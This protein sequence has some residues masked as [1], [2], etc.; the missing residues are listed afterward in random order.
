[1]LF[2]HTHTQSFASV[3]ALVGGP[4]AGLVTDRWGRKVALLLVGVPY[5][6]G[7]LMMTLAHLIGDPDG[8]KAVLLVGRLL[9][10]VGQGWSCMAGAVSRHVL[11]SKLEK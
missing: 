4:V 10:G 8:F 11:A 1:M 9:T 3:G 2:S 5:L 7:Y 6:V